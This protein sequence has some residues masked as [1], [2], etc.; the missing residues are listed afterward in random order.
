MKALHLSPLPCFLSA[1]SDLPPGLPLSPHLSLWPWIPAPHCSAGLHMV[2]TFP[3]SHEEPLVLSRGMTGWALSISCAAQTARLWGSEARYN[4]S[5]RPPGALHHLLVQP[6]SRCVRQ[7][8]SQRARALPKSAP[9][10]LAPHSSP[11]GV[12]TRPLFLSSRAPQMT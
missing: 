10:R 11:H 4:L 6:N 12:C 9:V 8:L 3:S 7:S 1:A 5:S 2:W